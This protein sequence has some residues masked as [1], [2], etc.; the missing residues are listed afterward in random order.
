[1]SEMPFRELRGDYVEN[2]GQAL[3]LVEYLDYFEPLGSALSRLP[4]GRGGPFVHR[5]TDSAGRTISSIGWVVSAASK[6]FGGWKLWGLWTDRALPPVA[7]P[8]L[9]PR[10][11]DPARLPDLLNRANRD[12]DRLFDGDDWTELLDDLDTAPLRQPALRGA[13]KVQLTRAYRV[14]PPHAHAIEVDVTEERLDLLP[15]LY[16]LGPVDPAAAQLTPSRFNGAGYQ[17]LFSEQGDADG[18]VLPA[19][20]A[21]VDAAARSPRAGWQRAVELRARINRPRRG[22]TRKREPE[23]DEM[24]KPPSSPQKRPQNPPS[25][26][27]LPA[28]LW[29]TVYQ[30]AVLVLLAWIAWNVHGIRQRMPAPS[31]SS[32]TTPA[33]VPDAEPIAPVAET[34]PPQRARVRRIAQALAARPPANIRVDDG[35]LD[36]V[37]RSETDATPVM[38]RVAVEIFLRRNACFARTEIVDG[39]FSAG[40]QRALRSCNALK[41]AKLVTSSYDPD[42]GRALDWLERITAPPAT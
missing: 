7:L 3:N 39:R 8:L 14:K 5:F 27:R 36:D 19:I 16:L 26:F 12:A 24:P 2:T 11:S 21:L 33:E 25:D 9:W 30:V 13:L 17:Y 35:L 42:A 40:E 15:W 1:M 6:R 41:T 37:L 10:L 22:D 31:I 32:V 38:A 4:D 23:I 34:E 18:D 29:T 28:A 20:D